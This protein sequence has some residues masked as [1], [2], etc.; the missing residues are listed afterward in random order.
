MHTGQQI[1]IIG[2]SGATRTCQV[3]E[4]VEDRVKV[5]YEGFDD[6]YDEW[7][8]ITSDR[9]KT[10]ADANDAT[11]AKD[12]KDAKQVKREREMKIC[13]R[14]MIGKEHHLEMM[15]GSKVLELKLMVSQVWPIPP[16]LQRL[17]AGERILDDTQALSDY[18]DQ[19]D[20]PDMLVVM[21]FTCAD[22]VNATLN[23]LKDHCS[24]T[25]AVEA[26][27]DLGTLGQRTGEDVVKTVALLVEDGRTSVR[28]AAIKTLLKIAKGGE[29]GAMEAL[30]EALKD[31]STRDA[32]VTSLKLIIE[33]GNEDAMFVMMRYLQ[34]HRDRASGAIPE[35]EVKFNTR[36]QFSQKDERI[37][38]ALAEAGYDQER[39]EEYTFKASLFSWNQNLESYQEAFSADKWRVGGQLR[40][41]YQLSNCPF[42]LELSFL[43]ENNVE[44]CLAAL[45]VLGHVAGKG[46]QLAIAAVA[47]CLE[48]DSADVQWKAV[49]QL[50][51]V[52]AA[53]DHSGILH[54]KKRLDHDD[55]RVRWAAQEALGQFNEK[56][57]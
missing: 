17:L 14:D 37:Q 31:R 40:V 23:N 3:V 12:A 20:T 25:E 6:R 18:S 8:F 11:D 50:G 43:Q 55:R 32:M 33:V 36:E 16:S 38:Q 41:P 4:Q 35:L 45:D 53:G 9:I 54:A 49:E 57:F 13:L 47:K 15:S 1:S 29:R 51:L 42:I 46:N 22:A 34:D 21:V 10:E 48:D 28:H 2:P 39:L 30:S 5:H 27:N 7:V 44:V 26:L 19:S 24:E 56:S 52:I